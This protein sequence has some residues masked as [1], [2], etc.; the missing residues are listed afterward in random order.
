MDSSISE[1][2]IIVVI[3]IGIIIMLLLA[4]AFVLFF[5]FS[6]KKF[7]A[8]QMKAQQ[9]D[10]EHQQQ[11]LFSSIEAQEKERQRIAR[12]L[13][14][15]VGS[16]LNVI[17]LGLHRLRKATSEA[18]NKDVDEMVKVVGTTID[19]TRR[20]SHD[21]LP[22]ALENFGLATALEELCENF[23][24]A[25]GAAVIFELRNEEQHTIDNTVALNLFRVVQELLTN[26]FKHAAASQ[27]EV[28]LWLGRHE[29]QLVYRDN[30]KGFSAAEKTGKKGLGMQNIESRMRMIGAA[31]QLES[32]PGKG[33]FFKAKK[34][35]T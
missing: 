8:H 4:M 9:R 32:E 33:I 16:K 2:E 26:S 34:Q 13:H 18:T 29:L 7:R 17:N 19:I 25:S 20:I 14:D 15:G 5:S 3:T 12:E 21:L 27:V 10:L 30:G 35:R 22:P 6:Q 24:Q 11:L 1:N 31:Y 23:R 28:E